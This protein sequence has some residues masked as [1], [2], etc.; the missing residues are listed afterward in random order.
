MKFL[1]KVITVW[2]VAICSMSLNK[3]TDK[4]AFCPRE[5]AINKENQAAKAFPQ[6]IKR[7]P[8]TGVLPA[9]NYLERR[10][11]HPSSSQTLIKC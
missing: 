8:P 2:V 4:Q 7:K 11:N 10:L 1:L 5:L 9:L 6:E 3:H